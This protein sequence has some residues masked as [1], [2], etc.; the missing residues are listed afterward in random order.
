MGAVAIQKV[1]MGDVP[2]GG[3]SM[4]AVATKGVAMGDVSMGDASMGG[5]LMGG[6][7]MGDVSRGGTIMGDMATG[8]VAIQDVSMGAVSMGGISVGATVVVAMATQEVPMG[9]TSAPAPLAAIFL[10]PTP[11][12]PPPL[13]TPGGQPVPIGQPKPHPLGGHHVPEDKVHDVGGQ[14]P[15]ARGRGR[16]RG[17][18][19]PPPH[20][21]TP[22]VVRPVQL[23]DAGQGAGPGG[24][25]LT[26][27]HGAGEA[28]VAGAVS[29]GRRWPWR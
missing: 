27:H 13:G 20:L 7:S 25:G 10:C 8:A 3:T 5:S 22:T 15:G 2:M 9:A 1:S 28:V 26:G 17:R 23:V 11:R 14:V 16:G 4:G 24:R 21:V 29:R 12:P 19:C 6:T 18:P